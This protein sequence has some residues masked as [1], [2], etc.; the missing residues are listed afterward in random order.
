MSNNAE[1]WGSLL[2][3]FKVS[4]RSIL[5]T[6]DDIT[7]CL[8]E[9]VNAHTIEQFSLTEAFRGDHQ[10][11]ESKSFVKHYSTS[12]KKRHAITVLTEFFESHSHASFE[13]LKR[14]SK[15]VKLS[16]NFFQLLRSRYERHAKK[17]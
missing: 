11:F 16:R 13:D 3:G 7:L 10:I 15:Q 17:V 2:Y 12:G 4:N 5:D 8:L 6:A 1:M 14:L 9:H